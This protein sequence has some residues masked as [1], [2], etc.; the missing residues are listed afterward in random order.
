MAFYFALQHRRSQGTFLIV[1]KRPKDHLL[2][3]M[4]E[5]LTRARTLPSPIRRLIPIAPFPVALRIVK[6]ELHIRS[7]LVAHLLGGFSLEGNR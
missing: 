5:T 2:E 3:M 1:W 4:G 6:N 7:D